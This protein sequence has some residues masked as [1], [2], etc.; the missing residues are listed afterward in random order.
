M[1]PRKGILK[2][3]S[4]ADVTVFDPAYNGTVTAAEQEQNVDHTPFEGLPISGRAKAVFLRGELAAENGRAVG[5]RRGEYIAR[6]GSE[7]I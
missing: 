1:F 3:G 2:E 4:D 7:Y 5:E 6:G